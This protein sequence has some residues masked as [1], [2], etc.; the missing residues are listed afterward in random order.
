MSNLK[1]ICQEVIEAADTMA[2]QLWFTG[3]KLTKENRKYA[4]Y[5]VKNIDKFARAALVMENALKEQ[6]LWCMAQFD[7]CECFTKGHACL[8]EHGN[9]TDMIH[10]IDKA[11]ARVEDILK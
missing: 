1:R 10:A 11:L 3:M 4:D 7:R 8:A 2:P 9:A 6:R 5:A